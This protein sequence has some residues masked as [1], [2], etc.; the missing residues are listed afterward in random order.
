MFTTSE[1][2][3]VTTVTQTVTDMTA[4]IANAAPDKGD[5]VPITV[6]LVGTLAPANVD[7]IKV[8]PDAATY[9]TTVV[10]SAGAAVNSPATRVDE[11]GILHVSKK[12][13]YGDVITVK[14]TSSYVNPSG[15]TTEYTKSVTA[16]VTAP[17]A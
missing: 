1:A 8:A 13:D 7:G 16:T 14:I 10:T 17:S 9:E 3:N 6:K 12:L 5:E 15:E 4:T 11:Y 2:T